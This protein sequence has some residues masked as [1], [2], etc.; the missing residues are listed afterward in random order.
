MLAILEVISALNNLDWTTRDVLDVAKDLF[1]STK[2]LATMA[3]QNVCQFPLLFSTNLSMDAVLKSTSILEQVYAM[4]I[5]LIIENNED[6]IDLAKNEN[7]LKLIQRIHQNDYTD[8]GNGTMGQLM[9]AG[10]NYINAENAAIINDALTPKFNKTLQFSNKS[11]KEAN[12]LLLK[13]Y[14]S[15]FNMQSMSLNEAPTPQAQNLINNYESNANLLKQVIDEYN[16][17]ISDINN[18]IDNF[19]NT[20]LTPNNMELVDNFNLDR[21]RDIADPTLRKKSATNIYVYMKGKIDDFAI[22]KSLIT[23]NDVMTVKI[24]LMIKELFYTNGQQDLHSSRAGVELK[25]RMQYQFIDQNNEIAEL[26]AKRDRYQD[27]LNQLIKNKTISAYIEGDCEQN[28]KKARS[29][30]SSGFSFNSKNSNY[31]GTHGK[32]LD[33]TRSV[34]NVTRRSEIV[35][36]SIHKNNAIEP[37]VLKLSLSYT[38]GSSSAMSQT[39][40]LVGI[41]AIA[42]L[43]NANEVIN[44][45]G[46][47]LI[48]NK[49]FFRFL[50]WTSGEISFVKDFILNLNKMKE[51]AL[52]DKQSM[53]WFRHLKVK[54]TTSK[55][56]ALT[57]GNQVLPNATLIISRQDNEILKEI[58]KIDILKNTNN[59]VKLMKLLF[60]LHIVIIDEE[61]TEIYIFNMDTQKYE[62]YKFD[63]LQQEIEQTLKNAIRDIKI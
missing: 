11:F 31:N 58:Y 13:P 47:S 12:E 23:S 2:S 29:W 28:N 55:I 56:R 34:Q 39:D 20:I 45:I 42:H 30:Q 32:P 27:I 53:K 33:T 15:N 59:A 17:R 10:R 19:L 51:D 44:Y 6:V 57:G 22:S 48:E 8:Y 36:T 4:Y 7:K 41:K 9:T 37:T 24:A 16:R 54:R 63:K 43:L 50:Q 21:D 62:K 5:K 40:I 61:N 1:D 38:N 26:H 46:K 14:F 18:D 25:G 52:S 3:R 60:L 49:P 35:N